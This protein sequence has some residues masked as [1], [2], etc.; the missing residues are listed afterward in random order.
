MHPD[1]AL[2]NSNEPCGF[3]STVPSNKE[4]RE[5]LEALL[6]HSAL[7]TSE[8]N[9]RFLTYVVEET[10]EG[11]ADR[12]KAYTIALAAFDRTEDFD[13]M[14]DPIVRIEASRLRRSL[15][16]Y[17][18]T[19]GQSDRIRIAIPKGS[20][21]AT[22]RYKAC[23]SQETPPTP[24]ADMPS[25]PRV[26]RPGRISRLPLCLCALSLVIGVVI[27]YCGMKYAGSLSSLSAQGVPSLVII[28]FEDTSGDSKYSFVARSLTYDVALALTQLPQVAIFG[29]EPNQT[30]M[31]THSGLTSDYALGGSVHV[32]GY[33]M[34]VAVFLMDARTGQYLRSW[35]IQKSLTAE[36]LI[37][38]QAAI[39]QQ[40]LASVK[41]DC[42]SP[43]GNL[44]TQGDTAV[45]ECEKPAVNVAKQNAKIGR[46]GKRS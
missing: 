3:A 41:N 31:P 45:F 24:D 9:R 28:P 33:N 40:I 34:R 5:Y 7:Q 27:G 13:P 46:A 15:E 23:R 19:D 6:K 36:N 21:V 37:G 16:H 42:A 43:L 1:H 44:R 30:N 8:R 2:E 26:S 12:I 4:V 17:Y 35:Y 29:L 38:V 11:R 22:F 32:E 14:T 18:L 39:A 25:I 10:L 20:Y